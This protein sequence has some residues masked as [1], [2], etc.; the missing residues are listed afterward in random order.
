MNPGSSDMIIYPN[1]FN[2]TATVVFSNEEQA[3]YQLV[4]Y[5]MLGKKVR[6][7]ENISSNEVLITKGKLSPGMYFLEL[8]G[9]AKTF[10]GRIIVE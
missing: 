6:R 10:R 8:Q 9:I 3:I 5:D 1:P 2:Q 7:L 4:L